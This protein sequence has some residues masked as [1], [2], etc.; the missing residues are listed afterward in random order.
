MGSVEETTILVG[1]FKD[2]DVFIPRIRIIPVDM[3]LQF[4][5][6][7]FPIRLAFVFTINKAQGQS[8]ELCGSDL[9]TDCFTHG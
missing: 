7:Q 4:K 5:R 8:L 2:R 6:L 9:E 3:P 1:S